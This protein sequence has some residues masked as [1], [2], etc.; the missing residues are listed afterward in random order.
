MS[1]DLLLRVAIGDKPCEHHL[2]I[3]NSV[4]KS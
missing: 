2:A 3:G 4:R 1:F